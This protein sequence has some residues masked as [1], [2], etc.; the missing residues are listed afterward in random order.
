MPFTLDLSEDQFNRTLQEI[1]DLIA[2]KGEKIQGRE[3]RGWMLF[4]GR[5]KLEGIRM[6][7]PLSRKVMEWF[8]VRYGERLNL[9]TD[10][11]H[12]VLMLRGDVIRFRC[13]RFFGRV[14][15]MCCPEV[16][17][18]G[19][20][21]IGNNRPVLS[22]VLSVTNGMTRAYAE[23]LS[24]QEREH[25]LKI[26]VKSKLFFARIDDARGPTYVPEGQADL[27]TAVEQMMMNQ[28]QF[29]P[30]KYSSLQAVEKFL[31]AYIDQRG[32]TFDRIHKL[33]E[34]AARAECL[35]LRP[36]D[37]AMLGLVQCPADV[38][39]NSSLVT[40]AQAVQAHQVAVSVCS[41]I[42]E[43]LSGR[44]EWNAG[45]LGRVSLSFDGLADSVPA[46][47]IS[48][49][50]ERMTFNRQIEDEL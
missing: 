50:K 1:D 27:R 34:L 25:F 45:V 32:A 18:W 29:G 5:Y 9:D 47:L 30:S 3:L 22:N 14:F 46:I 15:E 41:M 37:R 20:N 28:P 49:T 19:F 12:A 35:D 39:Y 13:P 48:R 4:C 2:S 16:M 21:E 24:K 36:L 31:K 38:R 40:K 42:A 26:A 8:S 44:S 23:S 6:D 33:N 11:G 7:D 43:Q 17:H 10:F